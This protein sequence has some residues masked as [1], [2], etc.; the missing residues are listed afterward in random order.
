MPRRLT[1]ISRIREHVVNR[2][3]SAVDNMPGESLVV[4]LRDFLGVIAVEEEELHWGLP[5]TTHGLGACDD[6]IDDVLQLC[7]SKR[8]P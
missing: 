3:D 4:M 8:L 1:A 7:E 5:P 6:W 2:E